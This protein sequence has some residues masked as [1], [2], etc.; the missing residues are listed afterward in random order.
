MKRKEWFFKIN[1]FFRKNAKYKPDFNDLL[2]LTGLIMACKGLYLIYK[3]SMWLLCGLFLIY[4]GWPK[5]VVK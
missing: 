3:P 4:L 2:I 1:G 5:R